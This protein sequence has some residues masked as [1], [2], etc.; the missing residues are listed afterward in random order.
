MKTLTL[1]LCALV[2]LSGNAN[3]AEYPLQCGRVNYCAENGIM[4]K[5]GK[6]VLVTVN[7]SRFRFTYACWRT[8]DT[9]AEAQK[10]LA[11]STKR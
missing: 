11:S 8:F 5:E 4:T 3:A 1:A 2:L 7:P 10:A 9:L 6:F